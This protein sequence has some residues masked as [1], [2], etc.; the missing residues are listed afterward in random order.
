[1]EQ[2]TNS[3]MKRLAY[4]DNLKGLAMILVVMGH[5]IIF[6]GLNYDNEYMKNIVMI[7]MPLFLFLNGLVVK[8]LPILD[9]VNYLIRK[10]LQL[11]I[12]L[13]SWGILI[14][15][16]LHETY[17]HFWLHYW[18]YG[19]WYLLTL[20][21]FYIIYWIIGIIFS[22]IEYRISSTILRNCCLILIFV[23]G[24]FTVQLG[25]RFLPEKAL[26]IMSYFQVVDY[27]PYFFLGVAIKQFNWVKYLMNNVSA[28]MTILLISVPTVYC[29]W[30]KMDNAL[31]EW[32]IRT[33]CIMLLYMI[34]QIFFN[35]SDG[36]ICRILN[37]I[38]KHTLAIY[39]IQFYLFSTLNFYNL[40][41]MLDQSGNGVILL[42]VD[43]VVSILMCYFCILVE[44]L[45]RT[46][47]ILSFLFLGKNLAS[48]KRMPLH[49]HQDSHL[50]K[51]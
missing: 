23:I 44:R 49:Q 14:T 3:S 24:Y 42:A 36:H 27:Y 45:L 33:L 51:P 10:F 22:F 1:M 8:K 46:S 26:S 48:C 37:S 31:T 40:Y 29:F 11:I 32:A 39:M 17:T 21:E 19:Y 18:K 2:L 12:P 15:L 35:R 9:N 7:E 28:V 6:C 41:H 13:L 16:F 25:I 50:T 38:G 34:A 30:I 47:P 20:F 43:L 5:I 4:I